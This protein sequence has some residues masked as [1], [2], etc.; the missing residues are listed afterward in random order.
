ATQNCPDQ[1]DA[2]SR[3]PAPRAPSPAH[4]PLRPAHR[5][6]HPDP[7]APCT[8]SS[9][10]ELHCHGLPDDLHNFLHQWRVLKTIHEGLKP[11]PGIE[12]VAMSMDRH[13]PPEAR[14][15]LRQFRG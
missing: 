10:T 13:Q 14:H 1:A 4:R 7:R 11:G 2:A 5:F 6:S 15:P 3:R 12:K 9:Q 8:V